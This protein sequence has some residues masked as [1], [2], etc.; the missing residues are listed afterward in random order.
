MTVQTKAT[1]PNPQKGR[2]TVLIDHKAH[3]FAESENPYIGKELY[4]AA[5]VNPDK[6]DLWLRQ[7]C[8]QQD[9]ELIE[10]CDE[11]TL[12][13]GQYF[14]TAKKLIKLGGPDDEVET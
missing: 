11:I 8:H 4:R 10:P 6:Y 13:Q 5:G 12:E 7:P 1:Q 2:V 3:T 9:D 14:Y